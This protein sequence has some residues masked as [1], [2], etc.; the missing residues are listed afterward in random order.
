MMT[1]QDSP[2]RASGVPVLTRLEE[3]AGVPVLHVAPAEAF[4]APL[5]TILFLHSF[6]VSKEL[7]AYFGY[8]LGTAGFRVL[9]PEAPDH[10][11]RF[12]GDDALRV[13]RFWDILR[14][15]VDELPPL[16]D[17][18]VDRGLVA[19][20]DNLGVAGT[21]MGAFAALSAAAR[22]PWVSAAAS[23]MGTGHFL[24]AARTIFPPFGA[25]TAETRDAHNRA[26]APLADYEPTARI[27]RLAGLPLFLWHGQRDEVV[28][29]ADV[30]RLQEDIL[31]AG[32]GGRL[33]VVSDP[34]GSH[35][36]TM[37]AASRVVSFF[38]R[39]MA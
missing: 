22:Y 5:P 30:L 15:G 1:D 6:R 4:D 20:P 28:P 11:A 13:Q 29:Y 27:D 3:L 36:V 31:A 25:F 38:L 16:R 8:M 23:L 18:L 17:A 33:E 32:G 14:Q 19:N 34:L 2:W 39:S 24:D 37:D 9:L 10:G 35:K 7:V 26:V 12:G 21:S